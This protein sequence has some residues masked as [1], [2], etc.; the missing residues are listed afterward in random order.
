MVVL[1]AAI[2]NQAGQVLVSR[3]FV[4]MS[5]IRIEGLLSAFP[6]LLNSE[7]H[8]KQH[9]FVETDEIRYVYQPM[10]SLFV[11]LLTNK[12][13]NILSDLATLRLLAKLVPEYCNGHD[14]EAV[15]EHS[16]ELIFAFDEV[17][18]MGFKENV[19]LGQIKTY[20]EMDS[21]EEKLTEIIQKSKMEEA[22]EEAKRK[23]K[24]IKE[25]KIAKRDLQGFGSERFSGQSE[26]ESDPYPIKSYSRPTSTGFGSS[27]KTGG[28]TESEEE[29]EVKKT[30]K[31][32]KK[33]K[34]T[35]GLNLK[36]KSKKDEND[37]FASL[38][39]AEQKAGLSSHIV[40]SSSRQ[41]ES[42]TEE[43]VKSE[44]VNFFIEENV[45]IR[46]DREGSLQDM[47]VN[48]TLNVSVC[49]PDSTS[50]RIVVDDDRKMKGAF[51]LHPKF[52]KKLYQKEKTIEFKDAEAK[53]AIGSTQQ[54]GVLK[55]KMKTKEEDNLPIKLDFWIEQTDDGLQIT[56]QYEADQYLVDEAME[57]RNVSVTIPNVKAEPEIADLTGDKEYSRR[58]SQ[59][60]WHIGTITQENANGQ[61]D[62]TIPADIEEDD[63][64]PWEINFLTETLYSG[65]SISSVSKVEDDEEVEYTVRKECKQSEY[66]IEGE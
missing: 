31:R 26:F 44:P 28:D 39:A 8:G 24:E 42:A 54:M 58:E 6:K 19:D 13:S 46:C 45:K 22:K 59:F 10:D 2:C 62:M 56:A 33:N 51:K 63:V 21:H 37:I 30:F 12:N 41:K 47:Q 49:D 66:V 11:L 64:F 27:S 17:V 5:R 35:T 4:S 20:L 29:Q 61:I 7:A 53:Y 48:G 43:F 65:L 9:T 25:E 18:C 36:K 57:L 34:K 55:W 15:S 60:I 1:S 14:E 23:A 16:F 50:I 52:N 40:M 3:Q 32:K 38:N